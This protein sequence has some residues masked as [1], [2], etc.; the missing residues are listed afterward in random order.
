[1][2]SCKVAVLVSFSV[3]SNAELVEFQDLLAE[4][5]GRWDENDA[6]GACKPWL[7]AW[8][9]F[10]RL[11][12]ETGAKSIRKFDQK[13]SPEWLAINWVPDLEASLWNAGMK[14][15]SFFSEGIRFANE[16][17]ERF[18]AEDALLTE[19]IRRALASFHCRLRETDK[20]DAF[21]ED[22]LSQD[23]QWGWGWIGWSDCYHFDCGNVDLEKA[24]VLLQ[25]GLSV[26]DVRDDSDILD[27]LLDLYDEQGREEEA[28]A[29]RERL[30]YETPRHEDNPYGLPDDESVDH[31]IP[32]QVEPIRTAPKIGR[33]QPCPCGSRKKYKRC[34]GR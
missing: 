19:N 26:P 23:P 3:K 7:E 15:A 1:M 5:Y 11:I 18:R 9:R 32:E 4:G 25:R 17:L 33:N 29:I 12:D 14:D 21:Y 2:P 6:I 28:R 31:F 22:W 10:L 24:E 13:V 34:C 20:V 8:P 27:R 30:A 16:Y